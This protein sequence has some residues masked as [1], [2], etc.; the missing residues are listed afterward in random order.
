MPALERIFLDSCTQISAPGMAGLAQEKKLDDLSVAYCHGLGD[1]A[2]AHI[3]TRTGIKKLNIANCTAVSKTGLEELV[4]LGH[5]AELNISGCAFP[6]DAMAVLKDFPKLHTLIAELCYDAHTKEYPQTDATV[7]HLS[8]IQSLQ[9]IK[10]TGNPHITR[11]GIL[12]LSGLPHLKKLYFYPSAVPLS[13]IKDDFP[14]LTLLHSGPR[15]SQAPG[16][17]NFL[18]RPEV[19][20]TPVLET[21]CRKYSLTAKS[22]S[23]S[24]NSGSATFRLPSPAR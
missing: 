7:S 1:D 3:G 22:S 15:Q 9:V 24:M 11:D 4:P 19:V 13:D 12:Q 14:H 2:M 8:Q 17:K 5:L 16:N 20:A 23:S 10:L 6:D 18:E 21:V